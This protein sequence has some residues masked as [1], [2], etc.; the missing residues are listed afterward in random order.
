MS[1]NCFF[2]VIDFF[3]YSRKKNMYKK[4]S[5]IDKKMRKNENFGFT[6]FLKNSKW[7]IRFRFLE[8]FG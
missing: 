7:N 1:I 2:K 8:F 5:K 3:F 6:S 4:N